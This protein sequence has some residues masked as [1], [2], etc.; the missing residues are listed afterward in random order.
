MSLSSKHIVVT[1]IIVLFKQ[2]LC[3][4]IDGAL[5]IHIIVVEEHIHL[6]PRIIVQLHSGNIAIVF[7]H[8]LLCDIAHLSRAIVPI[9]KGLLVVKPS[10]M[11]LHCWTR[12]FVATMVS[13]K[14]LHRLS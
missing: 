10:K 1:L 3:N 7:Q 2:V 5:I 14:A 11:R 13:P 6:C 4:F 8:Q 12:V 9:N